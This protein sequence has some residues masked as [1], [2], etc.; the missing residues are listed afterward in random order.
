MRI[1]IDCRMWNTTTGR[2]V[3]EIVTRIVEIDTQNEYVLFFLKEDLNKVKFSSN[4]KLVEADIMW[5]SYAE[6][7]LLP[8]IFLREKL[9]LLHIP[10]F[11]IPILYPKKFIV[12]IHDLTILRVKTGRAST[13]A[14]WYYLIKRF[15]F[16]LALLVAIFR[17]YKI[18]TVSNFV[19]EDIV[20]TF[21]VKPSKI[22]VAPN[23]CSESFYKKTE[24]EIFP[25]IA[26]YK[27][28]APYILYVGNAHPHKNVESLIEA[29]KIVHEKNP[30]LQLVL[31]GKKYFFYE[32]IE[33]SYS[34]DAIYEH[35]NFTG[36]IDDT[37]LPYLYSGAKL[38]V[39]PSLY[40]GF[41]LQLLEA[42]SC[43][44]KVACSNTTS[45]PEVG[46]NAAYYFNPRSIS[47][48]AKVILQALNENSEDRVLKGY[49]R[50]KSYSWRASAKLIL[51]L[52]NSL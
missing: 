38:F 3:R 37:D 47:D 16:K 15:G 26:K 12:T 18:L 31:G 25:V 48:M 43:G 52:Y 29:F 40:E 27:I 49:E 1:G 21:K 8:L 19:K 33:D 14:Y 46:G 10:H 36:F 6:Q 32:R 2:Y 9:D 30:D 50:V 28:K 13:H 20:K 11:N 51:D 35:L 17:S 4:I 41:G 34:K 23:A 7:L 24:T 5:H 42:F 39:N 45:L 22:I 44:T